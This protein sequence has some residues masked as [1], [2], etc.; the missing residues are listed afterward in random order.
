MPMVK[1]LEPHYTPKHAR[2]VNMAET[3]FD[4][5]TDEEKRESEAKQIAEKLEKQ[6]EEHTR[7]YLAIQ[8]DRQNE[9]TYNNT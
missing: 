9:E 2:W 6:K 1:K 5:R 4:L 8:E 3:E 7:R